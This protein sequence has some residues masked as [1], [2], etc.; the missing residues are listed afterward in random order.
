MLVEQL[1]N[2]FQALGQALPPPFPPPLRI[3]GAER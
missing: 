3:A 1:V 2:R